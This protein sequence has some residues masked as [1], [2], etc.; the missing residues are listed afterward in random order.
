MANSSAVK[1]IQKRFVK[2]LK[3]IKKVFEERAAFNALAKETAEE[4]VNRTRGDKEGADEKGRKTS[5][6]TLT[7]VTQRIRKK[8]K[9]ID[10]SKTGVNQRKSNLTAT[11][12]ML[13]AI[14]G[15][16]KSKTIR[17]QFRR[18]KRS[19]EALTDKPKK[20]QTNLQVARRVQEDQGRKFFNLSTSELRTVARELRK[21]VRR[22]YFKNR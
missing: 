11:G 4:L 6:G 16:Y 21:I 3:N 1:N 7:P 14:Y 9:N 22:I 13:D 18:G 20:R 2:E 17:I 8:A 19:F 15:F 10:T 5:L 12:Q